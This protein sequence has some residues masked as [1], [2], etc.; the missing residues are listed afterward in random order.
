MKKRGHWVVTAMAA[1]FPLAA[2]QSLASGA[3]EQFSKDYSCPLDRIESRDRRDLHP[4]SFTYPV[5]SNT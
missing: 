4:S 3:K 2:C 1:V 5:P